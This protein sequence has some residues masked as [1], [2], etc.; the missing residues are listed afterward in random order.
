MTFAKKFYHC[1]AH[2]KDGIV[3]YDEPV[4]RYENYQPLSG[5]AAVMQYGLD[6]K[7]RWRMIVRNHADTI[8]H[9][10]DLLYLD[11]VEP[12]TSSESYV[13]GD[14]ANARISAV[15]PQYLTIRVDIE[16]IVENNRFV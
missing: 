11:G 3:T 2:E 10:N 13:N 5:Y 9:E 6:S 1:V 15:L 12:N 8:F 4:V 7:K 14:G 16:G